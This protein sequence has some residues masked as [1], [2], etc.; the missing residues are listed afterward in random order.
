LIFCLKKQIE[1]AYH[2]GFSKGFKVG[3]QTGRA[4]AN[5]NPQAHYIEDSYGQV[6][7]L[8]SLK[9]S[10]QELNDAI[11]KVGL[12]T[13]SKN[14]KTEFGTIIELDE[15]PAGNQFQMAEEQWRSFK[16]WLKQHGELIEDSGEII[17]IAE[18]VNV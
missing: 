11:S 1:E 17:H 16:K 9:V 8:D 10:R 4:L 18:V 5:L 7:E 14:T 3:L 12:I 6:L 15:E 13:G 2:S